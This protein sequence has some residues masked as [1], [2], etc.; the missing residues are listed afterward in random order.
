MKHFQLWC[1][2]AALLTAGCASE[3]DLSTSSERRN[4]RAEPE[5]AAPAAD[6]AAAMRKSAA[7]TGS[8]STA[9]FNPVEGRMIAFSATLKLASPDVARAL[10]DAADIAR[11]SGG[12]AAG[13]NNSSCTLKIPVQN[14]EN[15]L[16]ELEKLGSVL[17]REISAQDVTDTAFDLDMRIANLEKLHAKL[18]ALI[19]KTSEVKDVLLVEKELSRVTGELEKLKATRLNLRRRVD[20]VTFRVI[21]TAS[22]STEVRTRRFLLPQ[23]AELGLWSDRLAISSGDVPEEPF[24]LRL[25]KGF[26]PV[27]MDRSCRF[28]AVDDQD[29]VLR[30]IAFDE[31]RGADLEFW[32]SAI[33]RALRENSGYAV[34]SE[35]RTDTEGDKYI[36]FRGERNRG[37]V[38]MRYEASC[39]IVRRF[40]APDEVRIVEVLGTRE[41]MEKLDLSQTHE[42]TR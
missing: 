32:R 3:S 21:F 4:F 5:C 15:A 2:S 34:S 16:A 12:Y 38:P 17:S 18:T 41:R 13:I 37:N 36:V 29:T 1:L 28:F 33:S 25:P 20:F 23:A 42:S 26:I 19:E 27:K 39:R 14:A 40:F 35:T 30:A 24:A 11:R 31:I 9:N 22:A 10:R 6:R 7:T 8:R